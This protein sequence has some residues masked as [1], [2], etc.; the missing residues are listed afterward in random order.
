MYGEKIIPILEDLENKDIEIAGGAVVGMVLSIVNSLIKYISNLT[1]GKEKY[2]DVEDEVIKILNDANDLKFNTLQAIDKDKEILENILSAYK[3]RKEDE[4]KYFLV[5]KES[6]EF[7]MDVL[8]YAYNTLVLADKISKV[9]NKMLSSDFKIC[10]YYA[11]ASV[12]SAIVNVNINLQ[13]IADEK[14]VKEITEEYEKI[15]E[16]SKKICN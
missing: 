8:K 2:K 7:C 9:G 16:D 5:C 1:I 13:S 10:K 11:F 6:V 12:Q 15:L 14:Y 3:K 4:E